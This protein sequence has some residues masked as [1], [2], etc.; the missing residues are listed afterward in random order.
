MSPRK[1][2]A[3][4]IATVGKL[5]PG[6]WKK[7]CEPAGKLH[8]P[9]TLFMRGDAGKASGDVDG[10]AEV[11]ELSC[12]GFGG[13]GAPI[14]RCERTGLYYTLSW[15]DIV[16]LAIAAGITKEHPDMEGK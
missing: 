16:N 1:Q 10:V 12:G 4:D 6:Q 15:H 14:I 13:P 5:C 7:D 9:G 8:G 11:F 2:P 3:A